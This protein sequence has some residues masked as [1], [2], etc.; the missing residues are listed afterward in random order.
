[1][2]L[3]H[4]LE[5]GRT[6]PRIS[7]DIDLVA[8]IRAVPPRM[9]RII[10]ALAAIGFGIGEPDPEGDAHRYSRGRL[11]VDLL[12]PDNAGTRVRARTSDSTRSVPVS[13]G[14]YALQRSSEVDGRW[15]AARVRSLG[16]KNCARIAD[17]EPL[18]DETHEAW[19]ALPDEGRDAYA[20]FRLLIRAHS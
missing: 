6:P 7:Q 18:H 5:H 8:D 12:T 15:T 9:P 14:T 10:D 1:M 20:A 2:V 17:A 11:V 19:L 4:A 3:L 13:G 16:E